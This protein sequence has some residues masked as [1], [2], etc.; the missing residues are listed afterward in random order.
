MKT[1][2]KLSI[3]AIAMLA[4]TSC[5]T[6]KF[7]QEAYNEF[8]D[9]EF[10]VDNMDRQHDWKLTKSSAITID[11]SGDIDYVQVLTDNIYTSTKAEIAAQGVCYDNTATLSYCIPIT[12]NQ[13]WLAAVGMDGRYKGVVPFNYGTPYIDLKQQTL[14]NEGRYTLPTPQTFSYLYEEDFPLPGDFDYNDIVMRVSKGYGDVSYQVYLTVKLEAVGASKHIAAAINLGGITYDEVKSVEIVNGE[15][16]DEGYPLTRGFITSNDLLLK[17]R[18]NE[19]IVNLFEDAHWTLLKSKT[20]DGSIARMRINT[21][22]GESEFFSTTADPVSVTYCITF[23]SREIARK[24]TFDNIDPFILEE[25]N[26]AIWEVHT[27]YYKFNDVLKDIFHGN[28]SAYD[29]HVSWC[30]TVPQ[31]DFRYPVEAMAIG[32][33]SKE[34]QAVFGPYDGFAYWMQNH[35][36]NQDW[37]LNPTRP[38]LLY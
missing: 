33:Y 7:D 19:A 11:V 10:M 8:V 15:K 18:N 24:L 13:L 27:Y 34:T 37:Y 31:A 2:F 3:F 22:H 1:T 12:Q 4:I 32:T 30:V 35:N 21:V 9:Y 20:S 23:K 25:Y 36:S 6:E 38:N 14:Q 16:L 17:G 26:G 28:E 29:N 5:E